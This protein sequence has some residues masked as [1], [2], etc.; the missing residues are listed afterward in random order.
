MPLNIAPVP[1]RGDQYL[2]Q[3]IS[4]AG[5]SIAEGIE[6]MTKRLR[7]TKAM[8]TMAVDGMGMDPD[9][10]DGMTPEQ[11]QGIMQG[12]AV[13][14][15]QAQ[16][17]AQMEMEQAHANYYN[18]FNQKADR[19]DNF[20]SAV[21]QFMQPHPMAPGDQGPPA[22]APK[23]DPQTLMRLEAQ[24]GTLDPDKA[25]QY[26]KQLQDQNGTDNPLTF[27][28]TSVPN[29]TI[30]KTKKGNEFQVLRNNDGTAPD[31][32]PGYQ[33]VGDGK[34][35]WKAVKLNPGDMT[36][37][38]RAKL[39][40][41]YEKNIDGLIQSYSFA[42]G[43]PEMEGLI[44]ERIGA[45]RKAIT[46]LQAPAAG[47]NA[48]AKGGAADPGRKAMGGYKIGTKYAGLTYLGGDPK[49]A[50]SWQKTP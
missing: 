43:D 4:G 47:T 8:R 15:Q 7:Q 22:P 45:H 30:V 28:T 38:D 36:A 39:Q 49:D 41:Q 35:T 40:A 46:D 27:D 12:I 9:K 14:T 10:V 5:G 20:S 2:F 37:T 3:G 21:N 32:P 44:K 6:S 13:R 25:M 11:I 33:M 24:A 31:A 29:A 19:E 26:M 18:R 48:P 42:K 50:A 23:L 17:K 34:G 16:A 1:Y